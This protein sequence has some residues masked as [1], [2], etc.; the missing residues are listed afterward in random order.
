ML[1]PAVGLQR[2]YGR[3]VP[4]EWVSRCRSHVIRYALSRAGGRSLSGTSVG[5][6][7]VKAG[8]V[9]PMLASPQQAFEG[10]AM[11]LIHEMTYRA[12][13]RPPLAI[14]AGPWGTRMVFEVITGD[15]EG[16][17]LRGKFVGPGADWLVVG[18]DGFGRLD[19]RGQIET[20]DG[21]LVYVQYVG[22]LQMNEKTQAAMS[23]ASGTEFSD[24]YFRTAPRFETG[25]PRYAWLNQSV[26]VGEGRIYPGFGVEY[27]VFRVS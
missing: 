16:P 22:L 18:S 3:D 26:F 23:T 14:G 15:I 9:H 2:T 8:L 5:F 27:R 11:E 4:A 20:H 21:A 12:M 19:V 13:L 24:Q 7:A 25:D 10:R 17:R 6:A 1:G